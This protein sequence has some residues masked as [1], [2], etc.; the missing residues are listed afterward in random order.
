MTIPFPYA[1]NTRKYDYMAE[2]HVSLC[3]DFLSLQ[4]KV[5][6]YMQL[7]GHDPIGKCP[8]LVAIVQLIRQNL[9][10]HADVR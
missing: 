9:R 4:A 10:A 2:V 8:K 7:E 5:A 3:I 1:C 6:K